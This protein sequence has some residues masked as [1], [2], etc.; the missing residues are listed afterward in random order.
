MGA[1]EADVAGSG[2][3]AVASPTCR[4]ASRGLTQS[5]RCTFGA[6]ARQDSDVAVPF[7]RDS[8]DRGSSDCVAGDVGEMGEGVRESRGVSGDHVEVSGPLSESRMQFPKAPKLRVAAAVQTGPPAFGEGRL[9]IETPQQQVMKGCEV[10]DPR[11]PDSPD[12]DALMAEF[13]FDSF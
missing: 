3:V 11:M 4:E 9:C 6:H 5:V 2:P 10:F 1:F 7:G 13:H 12:L 8:D